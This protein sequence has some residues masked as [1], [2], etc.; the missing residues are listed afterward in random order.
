M[1]EAAVKREIERVR[2]MGAAHDVSYAGRRIR[3]Y[4]F[5]SG[6]ILVLLHGGHGSWLHWIRNIPSLAG[7]CTL[8]VPDMPGFGDS[9]APPEAALESLVETLHGSLRSLTGA[10]PFLVAAFSFGALA[11][12]SLAVRLP[13]VRSLFLLGPTGH[14]TAR[15]PKGEL[16][17]WRNELASGDAAALRSI[18]LENLRLHM[19]HGDP[20]AMALHV[21]L[22]SCVRTRFRSRPISRAG[23]LLEMLDRFEGSVHIAWGA[24]DITAD[25]EPLARQLALVRPRIR[26][27][28][29]PEAGHW[30]AYEQAELTNKLLLEWVQDELQQ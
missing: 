11:A 25:P 19:M 16:K 15:R 21:Q 17:S 14:G 20:D 12:A 3:W 13:H 27:Q 23:G 2:A 28:I 18:M 7:H 4:R 30:V 6:P 1:G 29:V 10:Q 8:L 26:T 5:G 9:D 24:H 22:E